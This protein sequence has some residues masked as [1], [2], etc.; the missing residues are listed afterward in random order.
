[1]EVA[2]LC[3]VDI[4]KKVNHSEWA[5]PHFVIVK[6]DLTIRMMTN[7]RE[8]NKRIKQNPYPIPKIQDLLLKLEGFMYATSLD[9]NMGYYHIEL[10]PNAKKYCTIVF[11]FGKYKYQ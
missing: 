4:L 1:M 3:K 7:L 9:L 5:S 2:Q 10:T 8:S 6:K 11:P